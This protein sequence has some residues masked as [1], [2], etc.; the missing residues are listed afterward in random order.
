[1]SS[2]RIV[3]E[4][5]SLFKVIIVGHQD[6]GKTSI[7][8]RYVNNVFR[9]GST[10]PTLGVDFA[11][12]VLRWDDSKHVTLQIWDVAGQ[13][14]YS[15]LTRV[16]YQGAVG[17]FVV[18]DMYDPLTLTK[19]IEWKQDIDKKVF[20]SDGRQVPCMLLANKCDKVTNP[21]N[22][23]KELAEVCKAHGFVGYAITSSMT[24]VGIDSAFR[25][26]IEVMI[27]DESLLRGPQEEEKVN[28]V[29]LQNS[30]RSVERKCC[31][32]SS[33]R[34]ADAPVSTRR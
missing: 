9:V 1:M 32:G 4:Q 3:A 22:S 11:L 5:E 28:V 15:S 24:K 23:A 2:H 25:Q 21:E 33:K 13:E 26:M 7:I 30:N 29:T 6:T 14:R 12:K 27:R 8:Q 17:A 19:A 18:Y 34:K 16:Y 31:S 10:K 20:L